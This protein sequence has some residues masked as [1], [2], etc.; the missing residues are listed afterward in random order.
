MV[1]HAYFSF[2]CFD[3]IAFVCWSFWDSLLA[4]WSTEADTILH[5]YIQKILKYWHTKPLHIFIIW[6]ETLL[7]ILLWKLVKL[8]LEKILASTDR[9]W[10]IMILKA[11]VYIYLGICIWFKLPRSFLVIS[12][13]WYS[14]SFASSQ[15]VDSEF[16]NKSFYWW[17]NGICHPSSHLTDGLAKGWV[18]RRSCP[19]LDLEIPIVFSCSTSWNTS[20][21]TVQEQ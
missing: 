1:L 13:M 9:N 12:K 17:G 7:K 10:Q 2:I 6:F 4:I 18:R 15:S 5:V 16:Y 3:K 11:V 20:G 14:R 19:G 8:S 21:R